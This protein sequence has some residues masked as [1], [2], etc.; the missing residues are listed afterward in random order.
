MDATAIVPVKRFGAAKQ[1]LLEALDRSQR[2]AIVMAMLADVLASIAAAAR[3]ERVIVVTG[4]VRAERLALDQARGWEMPTEVF[5]DPRDRGHSEAATLGI[6][7]ARA[8][9]AGCVALLPGD[10]PLLDPGEL[11]L[12]LARMR[13]GR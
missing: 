4:E 1:R 12:A 8:L 10:C 6:I 11:D 3:V 9:G 5:R 2:A 7:R 13:P